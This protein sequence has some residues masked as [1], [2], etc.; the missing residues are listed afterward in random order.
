MVEHLKVGDVVALVAY[1]VLVIGVG[2]WS[3]FMP[4]RQGAMGYFLAGKSMN[5]LTVGASLFASN[6]GAPM[7]IGLAGAAAAS[8]YSVVVYEWHAI[9][10]LIALGWLFVP[11]YVAS[12][13]FTMPEYLHRRFGGRRLRI[14]LSVLA[15]L[16]YIL[17]RISSEIYTGALFIQLLLGWNMYYC[18]TGILTVTALYTVLGGLAAVI[19]TDTLQTVVL[20]IGATVLAATGFAKVGGFEGLHEKYQLAAAKYTFSN[21]SL[22]SCGLP[23]N[24]S[25]QI[26]RHPITGDIPWPGALTGLSILGLWVWCSD[27]IIV[28]RS[29]SAKN[30]DHAKGGS[31]FAAALKIAPFFLWIIPG[32]ISRVLFPDEVACASPEAC[33]AVCQ[34]RAGCSNIAYPLLVLRILPEGL[35]GLMLAAALA[36]QMST[37][38]SIF[39]SASSMFTIDIWPY[40]R[41]NPSNNELMLVGRLT[42][43]ALTGF[44]ILWLPILQ[45]SHGGQL[46]AYL[47][48]TAAYTAPPWTMVFLLGM[49][50]K[51]TTEPGAFWGLMVGIAIG[52]PRL[53]LEFIFPAPLCGS[54]EAD[55][56]PAI[57]KDVHFLY[58]AL[59]LAAVSSFAIIIVSLKTEPRSPEKLRRVTW[60]TRHEEDPELTEDEETDADESTVMKIEEPVESDVEEKMN[61]KAG[62]DDECCQRVTTRN[63]GC[64]RKVISWLCGFQQVSQ[65]NMTKEERIV[66][67]T[68]LTSLAETDNVKQL[69]D[70]GAILL[71]TLTAFL[72]G[73]FNSQ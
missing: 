62:I 29:L 47:Q 20:L 18:V 61:F 59:I 11:V 24:D 4:T 54:G 37:L 63:K 12:G 19:Y 30:M 6:V 49:F 57:L 67:R 72:F 45:Q 36:A 56:R 33:Y 7:F 44:G 41:K 73:Y 10:L 43:I 8:G 46:W 3:A 58:F 17:T 64:W 34:N 70:A 26:W 68:L 48:A 50:W 14:Y 23:R 25:F 1:F 39:N 21:T 38:T 69:L 71:A 35:R 53:C 65:T 16:L 42:V 9:Y 52:L 5:W 2:I 60:W 40:L 51:R 55:E 32:M 28:Q 15:L 22:Y 13:S 66:Q 27:Q 31:L